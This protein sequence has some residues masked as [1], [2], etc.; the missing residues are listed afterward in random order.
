L[1]SVLKY[2]KSSF[3]YYFQEK[4]G[5]RTIFGRDFENYCGFKVKVKKI[6]NE[7]FE[8]FGLGEFFDC[9]ILPVSLPEAFFEKT[10]KEKLERVLDED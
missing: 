6:S 10:L 7:N 3:D 9:Y 5:T 8:K 2:D 1:A 4:D